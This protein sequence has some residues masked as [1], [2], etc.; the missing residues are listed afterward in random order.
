MISSETFKEIKDASAKLDI[1]YDILCDMDVRLKKIEERK[2][3]DTIYAISAGIVAAM[4]T[5]LSKAIFWKS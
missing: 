3:Y 2:A 4:G 5:M 1:L